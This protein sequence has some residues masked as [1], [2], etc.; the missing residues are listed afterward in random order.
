MIEASAIEAIIGDIGRGS[1]HDG[2]GLRS[3][4]FFK[5]CQLH[6]P[7]C[8]NPEFVT[9]SPELAIYGE[10][11]IEC[12]DCVTLCP[13]HAAKLP[14]AGGVERASCQS[15]G[16]CVEACDAAARRMVGSWQSVDTV[17]EILLQDRGWYEVSGGG[18]TL[19]GGEPTSWPIFATQLVQ[20]L[21]QEEIHTAME[22]HGAFNW[23]RCETLL[24]DLDLILYDLKIAS[25]VTHLEVVGVNPT[26][27]WFNLRRLLLERR[28][29]VIVRI[30]VIPN[31]TATDTNLQDLASRL[32]PL[33]PRRVELLSWHPFGQSKAAAVGRAVE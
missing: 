8:H 9:R 15:C 24:Q 18:V 22:T 13:T 20:R 4:V 2:P 6:C 29:D 3:V 27:I 33:A 16:T 30:P 28:D 12:G 23:Q 21:R 32:R 17:V 7:W 19:S 14:A 31:Y 25:K 11:C 1:C 10:R 5:G 26:P